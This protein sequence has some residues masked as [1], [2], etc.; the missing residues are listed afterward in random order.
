M[1]CQVAQ[2]VHTEVNF[3][4]TYFYYY[5]K[6]HQELNDLYVITNKLHV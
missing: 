5:L 6:Y 4:L 3:L 1:E 2:E